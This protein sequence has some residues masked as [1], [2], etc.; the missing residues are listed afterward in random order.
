MIRGFSIGLLA[1]SACALT[2]KAEPRELR[3]FAPE[4]AEVTPAVGEPCARVRLDRVTAGSELRLAIERRVSNVELEPYETLRWIEAPDAYA[5]RAVA[6]ALFA[7][8]LAEAITGPSLVL[9]IDVTAFEELAHAGHHAGVV[10][11]H[12]ELRDDREVIARG[13]VRDERPAAD[14]SIE[15]VVRAIGEALIASGDDLAGRIVAAACPARP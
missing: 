9:D 4:L 7:R 2:S 12:Y 3:F 14:A 6:R 13:D 8:P 10:A 15:A 5:R 1:L 11:L